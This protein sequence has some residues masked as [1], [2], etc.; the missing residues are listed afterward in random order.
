[1]ALVTKTFNQFVTQ[2]LLAYAAQANVD[3][4]IPIGDPIRAL[5]ECDASQAQ[6]VQTM[7]EET[8]AFA[9]AQTCTGLDLDS[10]M[11]QFAFTRLPA[12][13]ASGVMSFASAS[14]TAQQIMIP[15]GTIVQT[16][17]AAISYTVIADNSLPGF[18]SGNQAYIIPVGQQSVNVAVLANVPGNSYNVQADQ[19][20]QLVN[21]VFGISTVTNPVAIINGKAAETDAAFRARFVDYLNSL[22][23]ATRTAIAFAVESLQAGIKL[24]LIENQQAIGNPPTSLISPYRGNVIVLV[25]DGSGDP[26]ESLLLAATTAV[27]TTIAWGVQ[28]QVLPPAVVTPTITLNIAVDPNYAEAVVVA[29]VTQALFDYVNTLPIGSTVWISEIIT[30]SNDVPG[31]LAIQDHSAKINGVETSLVLQL[32]EEAIVALTDISVGT[33]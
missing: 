12:Q 20:T 27:D 30:I 31:V 18:N 1:M 9:R 11:A 26:S 10:W 13:A 6:V 24:Q 19:L 17:G 21:T 4:N 7:D 16:P 22:S 29:A 15:V 2:F 5:A 33:F 8:V 32:F 28:Y 14:T 23:K 3:P 25:D